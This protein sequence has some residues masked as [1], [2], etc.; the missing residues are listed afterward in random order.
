[1]CNK[2]IPFLSLRLG[3]KMAPCPDR[4]NSK[5]VAVTRSFL[6]VRSFGEG[7]YAQGDLLI[8]TFKL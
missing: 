6:T 3:R 7:G 4:K 5:Q 8:I 1:M 2:K